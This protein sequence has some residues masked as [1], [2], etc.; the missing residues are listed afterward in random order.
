MNANTG[1]R[2][3]IV[4]DE[5]DLCELLAITL[6]G[7][8]LASDSAGNLA[9]AKRALAAGTY[10]LCLCDLRLPDG[11][12]LEL[13]EH[14]QRTQG[15]LPVAMITAHGDVGAAVAAMK[16]GDVL[17]LENTR[18]HA[19]EEEN[20]QTLAAGLAALGQVYVNDAFSA[21]HRAHASTEGIAERMPK[22]RASYE[23]AA[24]TPRGGLPPPRGGAP[25]TWSGDRCC[26]PSCCV[27]TPWSTC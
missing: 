15:Q 11:S 1:P 12:G 21:A 19:G 7:M 13:I 3:L 23:A 16:A 2:V 27:W 6:R 22:R 5:P 14:I 9:D 18:F 8:D 20:D 10:R 24:I 4:D 25:S 17:L 26:A